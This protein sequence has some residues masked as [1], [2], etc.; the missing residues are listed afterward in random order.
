MFI[1]TSLKALPGTEDSINAQGMFIPPTAPIPFFICF[2]QRSYVGG[3]PYLHFLAL[4]TEAQR[5]KVTLHGYA[6]SLQQRHDSNPGLWTPHPV[7]F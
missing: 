7:L 2:L 5:R 3:K 4:A 1:S 6:E